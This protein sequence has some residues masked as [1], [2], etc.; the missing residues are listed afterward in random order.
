MCR[1]IRFAWSVVLL[2]RLGELQCVLCT[3]PLR[4]V[5]WAPCFEL[6][7]VFCQTGLGVFPADLPAEHLVPADGWALYHVV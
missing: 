4:A 3:V 7:A 5:F 1:P 2:D 6:L